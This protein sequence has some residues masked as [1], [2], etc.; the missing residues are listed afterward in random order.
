MF[1][2]SFYMESEGEESKK[3]LEMEDF[4]GGPVVKNLPAS[5]GKAVSA[6]G[7]GRFSMPFGNEACVPQLLSP[8]TLEPV[9]HNKR[10]HLN[11][12]PACHNEE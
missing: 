2:E 9:F 8:H 4:P 11:E 12:R 5:A 6:P 1:G 7:A 10:N 3:I